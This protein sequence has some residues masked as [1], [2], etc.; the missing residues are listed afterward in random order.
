[1]LLHP[2]FRR[3]ESVHAVTRGTLRAAHALGELSLMLILVAI[4]AFLEGERL[5]EIAPAVAGGTINLLVLPQQRI[6]GL[7]MIKAVGEGRG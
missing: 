4:R 6:A 5:L 1:M 7:G 3:P 2:E